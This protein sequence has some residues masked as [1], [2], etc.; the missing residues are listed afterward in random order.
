MEVKFYSDLSKMS[1]ASEITSFE[2]FGDED[3]FSISFKERINILNK[4]LEKF[5]ILYDRG[6]YKMKVDNDAISI[7]EFTETKNVEIFSKG[8][9]EKSTGDISHV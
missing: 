7:K 4:I 6:T 9:K 1:I 5:F 3:P 8:T 2:L